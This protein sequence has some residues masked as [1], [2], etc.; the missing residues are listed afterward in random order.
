MIPRGPRA[1]RRLPDFVVI[2][3]LSSSSAMAGDNSETAKNNAVRD[4]CVRVAAT[5]YLTADAELV[6]SATSNGLMSVE[7]TIAE[8]RLQ[9]TYCK[10]V[11]LGAPSIQT[12]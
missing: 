10:Q 8:R 2:V 9:E 7:G 6:T 11:A 12:F 3:A 1:T 5:A 4:E